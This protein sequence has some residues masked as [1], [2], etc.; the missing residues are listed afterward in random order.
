MQTYLEREIRE[1]N[2]HMIQ[3]AMMSPAH[4]AIFPMQD[5]LNLGAEARMN[6]PGQEG[7]NWSWRFTE[8]AFQHDSKDRLAHLTWL[9][10]RRPDQQE[11]VYGDAAV[12]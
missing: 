10:R 3:V 11:K 1:I 5:I 2:W 7:G 4:T 8:D 12:D 9:Y 6:T